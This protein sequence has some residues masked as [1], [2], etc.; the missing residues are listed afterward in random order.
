MFGLNYSWQICGLFKVIFYNLVR[1]LFEYISILLEE[2]VV[3]KGLRICIMQFSLGRM[4]TLFTRALMRLV[5]LLGV[6][7]SARS[8]CAI[9]YLMYIVVGESSLL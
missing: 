9:D 3:L 5:T 4:C 8:F 1:Q 7:H 6:L 2:V